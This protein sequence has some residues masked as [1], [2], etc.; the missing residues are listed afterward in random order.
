ML[1][2]IMRELARR[3]KRIAFGWSEKGAAKMAA[4]ILK[5]V[6]SDS[7]WQRYW[8]EKLRISGNVI[9]LFRQIKAA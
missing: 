3:L 7:Q 5:R 9:L 1:G 4:I 8:N 2:R 6:T